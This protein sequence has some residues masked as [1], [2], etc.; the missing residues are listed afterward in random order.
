MTWKGTTW[1]W[2]IMQLLSTSPRHLSPCLPFVSF[3]AVESSKKLSHATTWWPVYLI[4]KSSVWFRLE[5]MHR[6]CHKLCVAWLTCCKDVKADFMEAVGL[7]WHSDKPLQWDVTH[8]HKPCINLNCT[9]IISLHSP[10]Y[11]HKPRSE[12][13]QPFSGS[14]FCSKISYRS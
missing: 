8:Y 2:A 10:D 11:S 6:N 13:L 4:Q 5:P 12:M 3:L 1:W 7:L 14:V 9:E